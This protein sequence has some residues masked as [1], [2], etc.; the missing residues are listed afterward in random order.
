MEPLELQ[1]AL[2][3]YQ[4]REETAHRLLGAGETKEVICC[5]LQNFDRETIQLFPSNKVQKK[6]KR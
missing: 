2:Q 5:K 1:T 4:G 6:K 3:E